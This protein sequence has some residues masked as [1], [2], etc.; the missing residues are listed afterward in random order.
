MTLLQAESGPGPPAGARRFTAVDPGRP[1]AEP[2]EIPRTGGLREMLPVTKS[3]ASR[4]MS[5]KGPAHGT[6]R[7]ISSVEQSSASE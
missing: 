4:V 5:G 3:L 6:V 7:G 2:P 1:R